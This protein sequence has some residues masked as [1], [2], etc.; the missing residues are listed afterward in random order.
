MLIFSNYDLECHSKVSVV[1]M[2]VHWWLIMSFSRWWFIWVRIYS[3]DVGFNACSCSH[4]VTSYI[5]KVKINPIQCTGV[6][7]MNYMYYVMCPLWNHGNF[8]WTVFFVLLIKWNYIYLVDFLVKIFI[9]TY[10]C[11]LIMTMRTQPK[12]IVSV[13]VSTSPSPCFDY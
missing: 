6:S 4:T 12:L 1:F 2:L 5:S 13:L 10:F 3:C 9:H 7:N 11:H 8:E